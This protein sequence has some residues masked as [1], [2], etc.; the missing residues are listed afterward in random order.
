MSISE[1]WIWVLLQHLK[2]AWPWQEGRLLL[3]AANWSA[4][5]EAEI[6]L[7]VRAAGLQLADSSANCKR[8]IQEVVRVFLNLLTYGFQY[9]LFLTHRSFWMCAEHGGLKG[10]S[11]DCN[12]KLMYNVFGSLW[13]VKHFWMTQIRI[14]LYLYLYKIEIPMAVILFFKI[15]G[16][17]GLNSTWLLLI[18]E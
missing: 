17:L 2:P 14:F 6:P 7:K 18:V 13:L 3:S 1:R 5:T 9:F 10:R 4:T 8:Q 12:Q 15:M 11:Q 16:K